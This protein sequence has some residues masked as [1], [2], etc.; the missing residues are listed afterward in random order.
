[1]NTIKLSSDLTLPLSAVTQKTAILGMTGSGKSYCMT[2]LAESFLEANAQTIILDPKG[3]SW[4]LRLKAD[5]KTPAF[6]IPVFGGDH[7]DLPLHHTMGKQI[8]E[9][10]VDGEYSAILDVSEFISSELAQFG[11]DFA[12]RLFELKKR[13]PGAMCLMID[14]AQDFM[15][16]NPN[17]KG[18]EVR[19]LAAFERVAKQL[20]SKG[21]GMVI[22]G[23]RPQVLN[24]CEMWFAFQMTG[25]SERETMEKLFKDKDREEANKLSQILPKLEVGQAHVWSPRFLK[26][27]DNYTI[28][29]K[30]TLDTSATPEVGGKNVVPRK[31][32]PV[33]IKALSSSLENAIQ[34]AKENDPVEL[35]KKI[36]EYEKQLKSKAPTAAP[37]ID[38]EV[39]ADAV[40]K[41]VEKE[42]GMFAVALKK[43][44]KQLTSLI[45]KAEAL[46]EEIGTVRN[47]ITDYLEVQEARTIDVPKVEARAFVIPKPS[48]GTSAPQKVTIE[49]KEAR[50]DGGLTGPEQ[51]VVDAILWLNEIGIP[52]PDKQQVAFI[53]G[54]RIKKIAG[55]YGNALGALR[56]KGL[57]AY[58]TPGIVILTNEG[59]SIANDPG[60]EKSSEGLQAA[61][62]KH[63]DGP[64][65]RVLTSLIQAYPESLD[66]IELGARSG[67]TV[68]KVAGAYGN[69][70]GSL[71]SLG[72]INYPSV[73]IARANDLLFID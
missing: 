64:E 25:L 21:V 9:L 31:L 39:I 11:Y 6:N 44:D 30:S 67:Y 72:L 61:I 65:K 70:L 45:A 47:E 7:A 49:R 62:M 26:V 1:M 27:S 10:L 22:A 5:G 13:K 33:D 19:M 53:A 57:V 54:Y 35:K 38:K 17:E 32:A 46:K 48:T 63:L 42:R 40:H 20:R 14:E 3:E 41:A 23:Q 36:A 73:G 58:P 28:G 51:R 43:K 69:A 37:V 24:M 8:A 71:R 4:G 59:R 55:A 29:K 66:K 68:T 50:I 12:T 60:I 15:P 18:M 34:K 52:Q 2:K 56:S 16:Q